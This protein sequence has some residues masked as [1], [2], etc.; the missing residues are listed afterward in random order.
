MVGV[1]GEGWIRVTLPN[2]SGLT[3]A[4]TTSAQGTVTTSAQ[5]FAGV[6]TFQ[7]APVIGNA[8]DIAAASGSAPGVVTTGVQSFAGVKTF[9][10]QRTNF[11]TN[12]EVNN[13]V[14]SI[15]IGGFWDISVASFGFSGIVSVHHANT[16]NG[17][18]NRSQVFF[19][20]ARGTAAT[21]TSLGS[22]TG[23]TGD[24]TFTL[25]IPGPSAIRVTN[26]SGA[27]TTVYMT[28]LGNHL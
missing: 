5:S 28:F 2:I 7:D 15:G 10:A 8:S 1:F 18:I 6:K 25:S 3:T 12:A 14:G 23:Q 27:A 11:Y 21:V 20:A 17:N 9:S 16:A 4:A 24:C 19:V 22:S 26:T 13:S